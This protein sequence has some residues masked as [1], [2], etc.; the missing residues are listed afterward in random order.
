M[1]IPMIPMNSKTSSAARSAAMQDAGFPPNR[2]PWDTPVVNHRAAIRLDSAG[3]REEHHKLSPWRQ[4]TSKG[5]LDDATSAEKA[6]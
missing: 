2:Q 4:I 1:T 6:A 3:Q 5:G